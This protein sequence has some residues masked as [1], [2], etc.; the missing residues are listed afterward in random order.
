MAEAGKHRYMQVEYLLEEREVKALEELLA[1]YQKY[2]MEDGSKPFKEWTVEKVFQ[3]IMETGS[4]FVISDKI[5][6][7]QAQ[8]GLIEWDETEEEGFLTM[9]ERR[10]HG[11]KRAG[12]G[13]V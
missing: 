1:A 3:T 10:A 7:A 8:M 9:E 4:S 13:T 11:T 5:Q 2:E 12:D 6:S